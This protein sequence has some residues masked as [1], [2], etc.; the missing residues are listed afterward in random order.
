MKHHLFK[1]LLTFTFPIVATAQNLLPNGSLEVVNTCCENHVPCC[2]SGWFKTNF[3]KYTVTNYPR[4]GINNTLGAEIIAASVGGNNFRTY[5]QAPLLSTLEAGKQ[6]V[7][8]VMVKPDQFVLDELGVYFSDS[9]IVTFTNTLLQVPYQLKLHNGKKFIGKKNKWQQ[10]SATYTATGT[11]KFLIIGNFV[12]DTSLHWKRI[13][14]RSEVCYYML[15]DISL[16][17]LDPEHFYDTRQLTDVY[18]AETR[19]HYLHKTCEGSVNLFPELIIDST[20]VKPEVIDTFLSQKPIV[21]RNVF[22]DFDRTELLPKSFTELNKLVEYLSQHPTYTILISGHTDAKGSQEY[23]A[24]LS[25][26]RALSVGKYLTEQGIA[27]YRINTEGKGSS[28]PVADNA[29]ES[30]RE[31]NRRVEFIIFE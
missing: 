24:K 13:D 3:S 11:E 1:I 19:R 23:N 16:T 20:I 25:S 6:Y 15:D 21:L 17:P 31:Q 5:M 8:T 4:Q 29:T 14:K 7:F 30:G 27:P 18:Y 22:F 9:L 28:E 12:P 26:G 10:L 2:P